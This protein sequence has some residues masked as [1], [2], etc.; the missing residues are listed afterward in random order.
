LVMASGDTAADGSIMRWEKLGHVER[1]ER[2][3]MEIFLGERLKRKRVV[4][5][6]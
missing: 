5:G 1:K 4:A 6:L 2:E 3:K